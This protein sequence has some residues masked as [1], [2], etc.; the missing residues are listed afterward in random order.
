MVKSA[1]E[2]NK[3]EKGET[4]NAREGKLLIYTGC[5]R[6]LT[7]GYRN[8]TVTR[9]PVLEKS[10]NILGRGNGE[11]K[12]PEEGTCLARLLNSKRVIE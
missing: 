8:L 6:S 4:G 3:K 9:K 5:S 10:R 12:S 11:C 2:Q 7:K 1:L